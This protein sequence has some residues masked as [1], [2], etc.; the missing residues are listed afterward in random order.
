[1]ALI[2]ARAF[3]TVEE[4]QQAMCLPFRTVMPDPSGAAIY[5][6]VYELYRKL[7]FSL[8]LYPGEPVPLGDVLPRL[9]RIGELQRRQKRGDSRRASM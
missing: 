1:M 5:S 9:R 8:G 3:K 4:A 2:A 7:Y 6:E